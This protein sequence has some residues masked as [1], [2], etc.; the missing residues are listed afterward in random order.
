[1][2]DENQ[3]ILRSRDKFSKCLIVL[4]LG[5]FILQ[6]N[7]INIF[8]SNIPV[9]SLAIFIFTNIIVLTYFIVFCI[10][11]KNSGVYVQLYLCFAWVAFT[12]AIISFSLITNLLMGLI[13]SNNLIYM[14]IYQTKPYIEMLMLCFCILICGKLKDKDYLGFSLSLLFIF[15]ILYTFFNAINIPIGKYNVPLNTLIVFFFLSIGYFVLGL[16]SSK[17]L[18]KNYTN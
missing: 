8:M 7:N 3:V 10:Q 5:N 4:G 12:I 17:Y 2:G 11:I 16:D 6:L 18:K 13:K 15:P 1:M 14:N 9:I